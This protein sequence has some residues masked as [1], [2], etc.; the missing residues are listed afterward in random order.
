[1]LIRLDAQEWA[2]ML[3]DV[4]HSIRDKTYK[5]SIGPGL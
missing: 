4:F 3:E 5:D 1:M 2:R